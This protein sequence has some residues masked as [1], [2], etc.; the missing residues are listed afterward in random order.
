MEHFCDFSNL[1]QIHEL[2]GDKNKKLVGKF[3]I[4]TPQNIW[5]DEFVTLSSKAYSYKCNDESRNK[6]RAASSSQSR[7]IKVEEVYNCLFAGENQKECETYNI[8]SLNHEM[9]PQS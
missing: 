6:L 4:E 3:K 2:F 9:Y 1:S 7:T 8:R 5:L